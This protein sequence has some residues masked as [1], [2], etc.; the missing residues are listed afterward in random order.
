MFVGR[1]VLVVQLFDECGG[2]K[3]ERV[4]WVGPSES[5]PTREL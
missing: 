2:V 3:I 4:S 1:I 5:S